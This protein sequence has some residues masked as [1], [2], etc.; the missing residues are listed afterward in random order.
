MAQLMRG[1]GIFVASGL[2]RF[3]KE[4]A[5]G[6]LFDTLRSLPLRQIPNIQRNPLHRPVNSGLPLSL[7]VVCRFCDKVKTEKS[8]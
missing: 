6:I 4:F 5:S 7:N 1:V 2:N 8:S 3:V